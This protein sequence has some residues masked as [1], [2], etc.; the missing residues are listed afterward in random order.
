MGRSLQWCQNMSQST[1]TSA[2]SLST[3]LYQVVCVLATQLAVQLPPT[4]KLVCQEQSGGVHLACPRKLGRAFHG[5]RG[6][7]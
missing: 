2:Q 5:D 1:R 3:H 6:G 4:D 7:P